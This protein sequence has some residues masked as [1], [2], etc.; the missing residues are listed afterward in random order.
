MKKI[1]MSIVGALA[2]VGCDSAPEKVEAGSAPLPEKAELLASNTVLAKYMQTVDLP[3]R[4]M[5]ALCPDKCDHATKLAQFEVVANEN[6]THPG[7]YGDEKMEPGSTAVVDVQKDII[8]QSPAVAKFI[9]KLKKGDQVRLT[10]THYYVQQ[11][12][13]QFPVRPAVSIERVN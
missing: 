13:G 3:C 11:G 8:G 1:W 4:Y 5:T 6:Y 10:I 2:L 9:S 7:Q 12:Q